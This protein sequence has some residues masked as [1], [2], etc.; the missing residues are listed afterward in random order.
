[1]MVSPRLLLVV[2]LVALGGAFSLAARLMD[3]YRDQR[4]PS[5]R[6]PLVPHV[7]LLVA[8]LG[9]CSAAPPLAATLRG[10][11]RDHRQARQGS[12]PQRH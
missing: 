12:G 2:L 10:R 1:M 4:H 11:Y 8:L 5:H 6:Q 7:P 9:V 3:L